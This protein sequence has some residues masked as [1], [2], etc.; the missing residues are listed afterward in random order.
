VELAGGVIPAF[1]RVAL[2]LWGANRDPAVFDNADSF[3]IHRAD[4]HSQIAFGHG[5]HFCLGA[6]LGRLEGWIIFE[7]LAQKL[8]NLRLAVDPAELDGFRLHHGG[9]PLQLAGF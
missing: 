2:S 1:E 5:I 8:P 3:D 7:R 9:L 4:V 6:P